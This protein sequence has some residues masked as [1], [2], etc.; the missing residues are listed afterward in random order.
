LAWI[1]INDSDYPSNSKHALVFETAAQHPQGHPETI[2][3]DGLFK[4]LFFALRHD[5]LHGNKR[6]GIECATV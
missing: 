1:P 5:S 3:D 6:L 2:G 4:I